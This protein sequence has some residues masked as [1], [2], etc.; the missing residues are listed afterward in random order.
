MTRQYDIDIDERTLDDWTAPYRGW[1][2]HADAIIPS[3]LKIPGYE[4]F[5]SFDVPTVYQLPGQPGKWFMS[6]IGFNDQGYNSFVVESAN[7]VQWTHP[8]LAMGFGPPNE[9]VVTRPDHPT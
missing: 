8:R 3:N 5:H 7:L 2:Y 4:Q 9:K 6:F 1:H